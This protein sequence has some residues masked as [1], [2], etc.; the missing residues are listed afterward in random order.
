[1]TTDSTI[2]RGEIVATV[3]AR[4]FYAGIYML[5]TCRLVFEEK[6]LES[7]VG[8]TQKALDRILG[9]A[10]I[11]DCFDE[12]LLEEFGGKSKGIYSQ[13]W[14]SKPKIDSNLPYP[15]RGMLEDKKSIDCYLEARNQ[16]LAQAASNQESSPPQA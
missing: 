15:K 14:T 13:I 2:E 9:E 4:V 12:M 16:L 5:E 3:P 1:M 6:H 8:L 7:P 11:T 10:T